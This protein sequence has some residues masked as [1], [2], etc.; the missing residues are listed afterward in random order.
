MREESN[1]FIQN[2]DVLKFIWLIVIFVDVFFSA[3]NQEEMKP[4]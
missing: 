1:L 3:V 4:C 2:V